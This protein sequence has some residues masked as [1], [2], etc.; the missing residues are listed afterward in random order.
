MFSSLNHEPRPRRGGPLAGLLAAA[1]L[2]ALVTG[3]PGAL[4][5]SPHDVA[6]WVA[7]S[8]GPE[9]TWVVT[10]LVR[11]DAWIVA[12]FSDE[13]ELET[14]YVLPDTEDVTSA[15][16]LAESRLL[17]G[18]W[19]LGLWVSDDVGDSFSVHP[20]LPPD[21]TVNE[22]L[23][24][25]EVLDDGVAVAVGSIPQDDGPELGSVWISADGGDRWEATWQ[26]PN[27][28][29][30]HVDLSPAWSGDGRAFAVTRAGQVVRSHD[31]GQTWAL[32]ASLPDELYQVA[33]GEGERVWVATRSMGLWRSD[34]DGASFEQD[35]FE[36]QAVTTVAAVGDGVVLATLPAE[37]VWRSIDDG[38]SWTLQDDLIQPAG[39]GVGNPAD[40]NHYFELFE[41]GTGTIWLASW[42]G[43][44]RSIDDGETWDA[45]E[46]YRPEALRGVSIT[47]QDD[48]APAA[49][50]A[51]NGGG[52][53]W[54]DPAAQEAESIGLTL[55]RPWP[56]MVHAQ[57]QWSDDAVLFATL[58]DGLSGSWSAGDS[59]S[60][61]AQEDLGGAED[62]YLPLD[63][64]ELPHVLA[65]GI[66]DSE[67][68]WCF[69]TD[70]GST[71]SCGTVEVP[72]APCTCNVAAISDGYADDG[73][74][75]IAC[76]DF[77]VVF[78]TDDAGA[79]WS[80]L[81]RVGVRAEGMAGTPW[82]EALFIA[83]L[84]GLLVSRSG[85]EPELLAF[86]GEPVWDVV[87]SPAWERDPTVFV[88]AAES[89]W[90]RSSDGGAS[91][92]PL[93]A[94][95]LDVCQ[96]L[97][98]SPGFEDDG[99]VAVAG[100]PGAWMSLDRGETWEDIH[101]VEVVDTRHPYWLLSEGWDD[102][103]GVGS[104]N[105]E[106]RRS[107]EVGATAQ[108]R[109]FGIGVRLL[110]PP[111]FD[112]DGSLSIRFDG[113]DQGVV[114]LDE[115]G[116]LARPEIWSAWE[117]DA[118]YHT[119]EL[120]VDGGT[121]AF[122]AVEIQRLPYTLLISDELGGGCCKGRCQSSNRGGAWLFPPALLLLLARRR[123][124]GQPLPQR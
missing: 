55:S 121:A 20:D 28:A 3:S 13:A 5:H 57:P 15:V 42:E 32:A 80:E 95:T 74:A 50:L 29:L 30:L 107:A 59:W 76:G 91:W 114:H 27:H 31:Y 83:S 44:T 89:G 97:S 71:Y 60:S 37:A 53:Q 47:V 43:I 48:G 82:G 72:D 63:F 17:L 117:L 36:G 88:L 113:E 105:G 73:L 33:V 111:A 96:N 1:A 38:L 62:V 124:R 24:S 99:A 104:V 64:A 21:A 75:W 78:E 56:R 61:L 18:T 19:G 92:D 39:G 23:A 112:G 119:L 4:G 34:N 66:V 69:S 87:V 25:P 35:A 41:D 79:H 110:A 49:V 103:E 9:P 22:V 109:F 118:D 94:P 70:S 67:P 54:V 58:S 123:R 46:T 90:F 81:G 11:F 84:D 40:G 93:D 120:T 68:G 85:A 100:F 108:V 51:S 7:V 102:V 45:I 106:F 86:G 101:A 14:R 10:S 6:M 116:G 26:Y 8:P 16:M 98:I 122:D 2:A 52:M 12:R 77:G 115:L 65:V